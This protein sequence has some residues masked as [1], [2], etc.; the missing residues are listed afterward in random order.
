M[1]RSGVEV[2]ALEPADREG[3]RALLAANELPTD[4]LDDATIEL[5]GAFDA[6]ALIGVIGLQT[7][8]RYGLLR[9]LVVNPALRDRGVARVLCETVFTSARERQLETLWLLTTSAQDYFTRH[10][11]S[12]VARD[13]APPP[14]RSTSQFVSLCPSTAIVMRR[15]AA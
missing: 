2:R 5:F 11:F 14:I 13:E 8:E 15:R 9:S 12:I 10:G 3:A 6:N 7:R 4:D 1:Q